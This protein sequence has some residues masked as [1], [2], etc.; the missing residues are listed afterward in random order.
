MWRLKFRDIKF[1]GQTL[2]DG[3]QDK[4]VAQAAYESAKL[5]A[6]ELKA[7][8]FLELGMVEHGSCWYGTECEIVN[9]EVTRERQFDNRP[10]SMAADLIESGIDAST[11][12][13]MC[14]ID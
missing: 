2:A 12:L 11:A 9:G 10:G 8:G 7:T 6:A 4:A 5:K 3:I 13:A 1:H 14:N